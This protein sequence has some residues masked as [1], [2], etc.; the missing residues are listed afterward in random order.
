M[1][2]EKL[3]K[4]K[5]IFG[6]YASA[7]KTIEHKTV[8]KTALTDL[9]TNVNHVKNKTTLNAL[10]KTLFIYWATKQQALTTGMHMLGGSSL[11]H[12]T[13]SDFSMRDVTIISGKLHILYMT[14]S[15]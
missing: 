8:A 1:G 14:W 13:G 7:G 15:L 5:I 12:F 9:V 2:T 10:P 6:H 11:N 3:S 4:R